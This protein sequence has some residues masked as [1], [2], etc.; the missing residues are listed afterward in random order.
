MP[1]FK[2]STVIL[3]VV[4]CARSKTLSEKN[5]EA[6]VK[7]AL[8]YI[9]GDRLILAPDCGLGFLSEAMITEKL[10]NMVNV[11]KSIT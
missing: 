8:K 3:G 11:A 6:R 1:K 4:K 7:E 9:D 10:T 5:I 2:Q